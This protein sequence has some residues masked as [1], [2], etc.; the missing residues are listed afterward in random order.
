MQDVK[1]ILPLHQI[2]LIRFC[3]R[4]RNRCIHD[5][6]TVQEQVLIAL[7]RLGVVLIADIPMQTDSVPLRVDLIA[8]RK[9]SRAV[10][11]DER[12]V[13]TV[14]ERLQRLFPVYIIG[15]RNIG[16]I[17]YKS[18][19]KIRDFRFFRFIAP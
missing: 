7:I 4:R 12:R 16:A 1:R 18:R 8:L 13:H 2:T 3:N 10:N 14:P 15:K 17:E 9:S 11:A 6:S 5:I 19:N